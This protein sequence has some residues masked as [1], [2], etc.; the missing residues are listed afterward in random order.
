MVDIS[1][2]LNWKFWCECYIESFVLNV[3]E[4]W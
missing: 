4:D 1:A 3:V 2:M